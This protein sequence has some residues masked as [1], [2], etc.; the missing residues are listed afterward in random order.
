MSKLFFCK[1]FRTSWCI[2]P[3]NFKKPTV[4]SEIVGFL[5]IV[6]GMQQLVRKCLQKI[7]YDIVVITFHFLFTGCAFQNSASFKNNKKG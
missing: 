2:S 5:K 7:N 3:T 6:G 1:R 4:L